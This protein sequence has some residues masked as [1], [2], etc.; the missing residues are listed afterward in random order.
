M[1]RLYYQFYLTIVVSLVLVVVVGSGLWRLVERDAASHNRHQILGELVAAALAPADAPP[2]EQRAVLRQLARRLATDLTLYDSNRQP[3]A[4]AGDSLLLRIDDN[5]GGRWYHESGRPVWTLRLPDGR[6]IVARL[7]GQSRFSDWR[8]AFILGGIALAVAIAALP[9]ARRITRRLERLQ[10]G[11]ESLGA[12][13]L[14]A[15]VKVEGRDEVAR[16][17]TSFNNAAARIEELVGSHKMLLAN[18]SH[19]LR[20]PLARIRMAVELLNESADSVRKA[21]LEQD[22]AELDRLIEEIL[23]ASRLDA[24]TDVELNE[25]I[26]LLALAA[27]EA[28]RYENCD[29]SGVS[30]N[31][32]GDA[33]LLRRLVRN[34]L[35]NA[36]RYGRPPIRVVV[37][38]NG[39]R[40]ALSVCDRGP[41]VRAEDREAIFQPFFRGQADRSKRLGSGLGLT[42]VRQIAQRHGGAVAY[43][44][45]AGE[46]CF[47]VRL[48]PPQIAS[49]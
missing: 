25:T 15:R 46:T 19:E 47:V 18:A 44:E 33:N 38:R 29:V 8:I 31:V 30:E 22:I 49:V 32:V 41:G 34:L 28:S 35:D 5:D 36:S 4:V 24:D 14:A 21:A 48:V 26:D 11:V 16:L 23:L 17:A 3:I 6:W 9:L 12:G 43:R 39:D 10:L 37:A 27:E 20:T 2:D 13:D 45:A 7:S 1:R 40:I 42:L